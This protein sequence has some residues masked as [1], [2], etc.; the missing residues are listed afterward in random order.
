MCGIVGWVDY[1]H[2]L[3]SDPSL[4][5]TARSMTDT[6]ACRGPDDEGV[7]TA[8]RCVLGHRRLSIIDRAGGAQPMTFAAGGTTVAALT[9]CGEVYNFTELRAELEAA[10]HVFRT[11]SDTE[12]VL[13]AYLEWGEQFVDRLN[14]MYAF[15]VWDARTEELVLV[16]DRMGVKPLYYHRTPHG[17]VFG[18]EL[19]ALFT[20][21]SVPRSVDREG[22]CEALDM[23]KTPG[24]AVFSGINEVR[25]GE[26]L[27]IRRQGV[28]ARR[29]WRLE[30][31]EH[32]ESLTA[33]ISTVRGLL[34]DIVSRQL[35]SDVPLCSLLSGGLDSSAVTALAARGLKERGEGPVRSFAV[36]FADAGEGFAPDAV[37][38]SPDAPF[39]RELA[40]HV[41]ADHSEV[42]LDSAE[43]ADPAVRAAVLRATDL[44]PAFWGDMWP[45]LYLLFRAV[46]QRSTVALSGESADELFGGYL[47]FRNP[48]AVAADT[49][50]WL[51]SG[52]ARYFGGLG[53][54]DQGLREKLDI[55]G[56][57]DARYREALAEVP[58][59]PGE[60][61]RERRMREITYLNLTRFVQTLLDR[62]D[63]MSMAVGLEV[64]VPFCDHRL[65]EYVSNVPWAMKTFDGREKSLLRAA[66]ADLLPS[67]VLQR[68]KTPYPATLDPR[69][70]QAL[71]TELAGVLADPDAPVR[72]LLDLGK[73]RRAADREASGVSRPYDRGSVEM[74][75]W[76]D[77]WLRRYGVSLEI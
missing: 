52:S 4:P 23:V 8:R 63:R 54:L 12:V 32:T 67:S 62:K 44:P 38:A 3:S 7:F 6:L 70:A 49:F 53:L 14:G 57:R 30:A 40:A 46:R 55:P 39:A 48:N 56:Y 29:Y 51:T 9:F 20:H 50:P 16:R 35:V 37:R 31:R 24:H 2:E 34:E 43:L 28:L 45:S 21:P 71:R 15:G 25:P 5:A 33:T 68:A 77:A 17:L 65:V 73:A 10:G 18:S 1:E 22:L 36:D 58:V 72:P 74:A 13:H 61:A 47:W 59:L 42:L 76:L 64:R 69:Y 19:K 11:R 27:R 41:G 75:L 60:E 66:T 26:V